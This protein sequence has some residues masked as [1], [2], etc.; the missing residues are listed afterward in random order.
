SLL[1]SGTAPSS[2]AA[3]PERAPPG[4]CP[5]LSGARPRRRSRSPT[6]PDPGQSRGRPPGSGGDKPRPARECPQRWRSPAPDAGASSQTPLWAD[7]GTAPGP[8]RAGPCGRIPGRRA[9]PE[10]PAAPL[11]GAWM[12]GGR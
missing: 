11:P 8:A 12:P 7:P 6:S 5:P 1:P 2:A 4:G 10:M 9:S 3:P